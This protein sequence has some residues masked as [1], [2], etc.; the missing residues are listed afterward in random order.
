MKSCPAKYA[1][2]LCLLA[3]VITTPAQSTWNYFIS[4][5]GGGNS[6][7]TWNVTGSLATSPGAVLMVSESSLAVSVNAPGIYTDAYLADGTPQALPT[8]DG[9]YFQFGESSVYTAISLY[10]TVNAPGSGS[11]TFG[12]SSPPLPPHLAGPGMEILYQPGTQSVLIPVDFSD[13]N[14]GTYQS[15]ETGFDTSLTVNLTVGPVPEPS[16]LALSAVG[17]LGGLLLFRRRQSSV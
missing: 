6:L 2:G 10:D 14:P 7:V 17:G 11:D 5:A 4:D 15:V 3:A 1:G 13:F 8:P 12:L 9:S 16:L